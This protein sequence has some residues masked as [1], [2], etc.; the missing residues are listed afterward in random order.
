M[1]N[2][3][4]VIRNE[5]K[6][7]GFKHYE[8][9]KEIGISSFTLSVWLRDE[10]TED[11]YERVSDAIIKLKKERL[12]CG[13]TDFS[14]LPKIINDLKSIC[15]FNDENNLDRLQTDTFRKAITY[16]CYLKQIVEED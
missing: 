8:I 12:G 10:L 9:A 14:E 13:I 2:K 3:N 4:L 7:S 15:E 5:I 1:A 11:R 6:N 16:L